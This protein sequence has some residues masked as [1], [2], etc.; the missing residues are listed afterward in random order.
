MGGKHITLA[1][2]EKIAAVIHQPEKILCP[3]GRLRLAEKTTAE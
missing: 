3:V 2:S 1:L